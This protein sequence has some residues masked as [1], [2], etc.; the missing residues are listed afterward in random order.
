[1]KIRLLLALAG[2][3]LGFAVLILAGLPTA[4]RA[5]EA[6]ATASAGEMVPGF[7]HQGLERLHE[8]L[9]AFVDSGQYAGTV[10]LLLREGQVAD[11]YAYGMRDLENKLPMGRD[12]ICRLYSLSKIVSTV[13]AL[14]LVEQG[15]LDLG[16]PVENY[17]PQLANRQVMVG[18]TAD[19]PKLQ[20]AS[21]P[22]TL[23]ELMTHMAGFIYGGGPAAISEVWE[24]AHLWDSKSLSE[25]V[26]RLAPLPLVHDPGT[27]FEYSVSIDVLGAVVE[28]VSGQPFEQVLRERIFEPLGMKDTGFSVEPAKRDRLAKTYKP[29]A[30][31]RLVEAAPLIGVVPEGTGA[32][33]GAGLF[34]TIDDFAR[35]AQMLCDN[36]TANGHR[37]LSRK[38]VDLMM[39]NQLYELPLKYN[40]FRPN[41][42]AD[43]FGLGGEVRI[44]AGGDRL[45]SVGDYGWYSAATGFC[46]VN[47]KEK[48]VALCFTEHFTGKAQPLDWHFVRVFANL[49]NQAL[50]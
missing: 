45:G 17:L 15:K 7:N 9:R 6:P 37:I 14:T 28:K 48:L 42:Q 13:A 25:F 32:W 49:Y 4:S 30:D 21:H 11:A 38:T 2:S 29:G 24:R 23:R 31:G 36:G 3:A 1:M 8:G 39:A 47:R 43:G 20:P 34:S 40:T 18:G 44:E 46:K 12:T 5:A 41:N 35:F 27:T 19:A 16:D 50:E 10:S 26:D 33:P 22:F